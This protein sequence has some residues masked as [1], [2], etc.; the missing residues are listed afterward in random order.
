MHISEGMT[1]DLTVGKGGHVADVVWPAPTQIPR[2]LPSG[3]SASRNV[4]SVV[5][6]RQS[7]QVAAPAPSAE[8][9]R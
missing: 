7:A 5:G 8:V 4:N 9:S 1:V 2:W 6:R 3:V